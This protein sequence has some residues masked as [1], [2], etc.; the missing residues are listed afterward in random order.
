MAAHAIVA[1]FLS[2]YMRM[3]LLTKGVGH[4]VLLGVCRRTIRPIDL[5]LGLL[6]GIPYFSHLWYRKIFYIFL[7]WG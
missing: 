1:L 3:N 5:L 6:F 2:L 7:E 4:L